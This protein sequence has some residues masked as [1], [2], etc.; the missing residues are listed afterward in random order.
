MQKVG[1]LGARGCTGRAIQDR[2]P[3]TR[4]PRVEKDVDRCIL[5]HREVGHLPQNRWEE[6][7]SESHE[8]RQNLGTILDFSIFNIPQSVCQQIMS[9]RPS[10]YVVNRTASHR[11]PTPARTCVNES[12]AR[13]SSVQNPA[14]ASYVTRSSTGNPDNSLQGPVPPG[15]GDFLLCLC[16]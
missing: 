14:V 9:A 6:G 3:A 13:H 15:P 2:D 4:E 1:Y 16:P 5:N 12:Q 11:P 7:K 8:Y 10:E